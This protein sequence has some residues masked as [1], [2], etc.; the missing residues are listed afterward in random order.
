MIKLIYI[1]GYGHSGSTLLEYL[2]AGSPAVLACGEVAS[3]I[4]DKDNDGKEKLCS[5][6]RAPD[7]CPV[8]GPFHSSDAQPS[9][10]HAEVLEALMQRAD[11]RY[12]A[13]ID[14]SKTAWGS[15]TTPFRLRRRYGSD[16]TLVH[17]MRQP[18]AV[19]WSVLRKKNRRARKEGRRPA[20]YMLR[21][22]FAVAAWSI[23]N[24]SCELFG[25]LYPRQYVRLRYEDLVHAPAEA[26]QSLFRKVLPGVTWSFDDANMRDNRHQLHGN[27]V[28]RHQLG[29]T[30]VKE[31]LKWQSEMPPEYSRVVLAL[32]YLLRLRYGY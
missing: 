16:F 31:D 23:A 9:R 8:W 3:S 11:G 27:S 13:I 1:G 2:M 4:R 20:H 25:F 15:F 28:K 32:S 26:L 29:I 19:S 10:T 18:A 12:A 7:A 21:C 22:G 5:C 6:G 30:D 14:S 17:L 24:L